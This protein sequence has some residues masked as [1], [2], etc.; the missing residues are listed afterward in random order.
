MSLND[1]D[2]AGDDATGLT[3][4]PGQQAPSPTVAAAQ[5]APASGAAA[6]VA[7]LPYVADIAGAVITKHPLK[8][9]TIQGLIVVGIGAVLVPLAS[10]AGMTPPDQQQVVDFVSVGASIIGIAVALVGRLLARQ[11]IALAA[12]KP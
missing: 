10:K 3:P 9:V 8:S 1:P 5:P 7:L 6:M 11:P 4:I 2:A 12:P